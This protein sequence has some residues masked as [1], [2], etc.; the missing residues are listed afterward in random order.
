[1][2]HEYPIV[3]KYWFNIIDCAFWYKPTTGLY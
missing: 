3:L 1:M 2:A